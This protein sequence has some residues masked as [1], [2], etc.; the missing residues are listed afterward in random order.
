MIKKF[1][2]TDDLKVTILIR[3]MTGLVFISE[4]IQKFIFAS[5]LGTGRFEK[6][7]L[8]NPE[9]LGPFVGTFEI[10]CGLFV[11]VG[12]LT[13]FASI[14][15]L[16]IMIV[17]ITSTKIKI[18]MESGIWEMLHASRNDWS[19]LIGII[20]L[21]IKGGGYWSLDYKLFS[22]PKN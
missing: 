15:L 20:F 3:I 6:I 4:G 8:P 22:R 13:R 19:M 18:L 9:F 5:K 7:G 16:I 10:L 2:N 12:F 11:L 21:L 14:P 17:A 1:L